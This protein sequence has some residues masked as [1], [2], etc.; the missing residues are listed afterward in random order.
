MCTRKYLAVKKNDEKYQVIV[1]IQNL[2]IFT[3]M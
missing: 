1:E 2:K 3:Q